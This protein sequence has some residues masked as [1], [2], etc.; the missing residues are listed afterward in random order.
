MRT[1]SIFLLGIFAIFTATLACT[2]SEVPLVTDVIP[3]PDSTATNIPDT[4]SPCGNVLYPFVPGRQWV[5]QKLGLE[6]DGSTPDPLTSKFGITV[7]E[8]TDSQAI[9]NAVDLATG[10]T[11]QTTADCQDGAITNFPLMTL[12]SLF[13]SYLAGDFQVEYVSG[14]F[15]P[16]AAELE[17]SGWSMQWQGDYIIN[18]TVTLSADGNQV[19][20][21]LIDSPVYM[22][23]Q[24]VGQET[25]T[26]PAGTFENAY[27]IACTTQMDATITAEDLIG[28]GTILIETT[29]WFAPNIGL[30]KTEITSANMTTL[31]IS[32]PMEINS[33]VVLFETH[34]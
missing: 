26:V 8:I 25:I 17:S 2:V 23:W 33:S 13:G 19:T 10:A 14:V 9:L 21:T 6:E 28:T 5:Y 24:I 11:F 1:K 30:L 32:F 22:T 27:K 31:G 34:P 16:S 7:A 3:L 15:A 4:S 12:G 29:R 20:I 18:G